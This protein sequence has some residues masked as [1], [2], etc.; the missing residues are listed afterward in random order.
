VFRNSEF[1]IQQFN[2]RPSCW[3]TYLVAGSTVS[4]HDL[5]LNAGPVCFFCVAKVSA[6]ETS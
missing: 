3:S 5:G 1:N 2:N 4:K 6:S